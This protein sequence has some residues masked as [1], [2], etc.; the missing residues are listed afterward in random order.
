[1]NQEILQVVDWET[2]QG[3]AADL[4]AEQTVK[5]LRDYFLWKLRLLKW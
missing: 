1:M 3:L 2:E 4:T 5:V